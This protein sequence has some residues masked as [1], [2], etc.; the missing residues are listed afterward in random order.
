[1]YCASSPEYARPGFGSRRLITF[2]AF[3]TSS[4]EILRSFAIAP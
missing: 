4:I 3:T 2:T 1:M